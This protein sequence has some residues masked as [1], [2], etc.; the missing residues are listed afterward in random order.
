VYSTLPCPLRG[1]ASI[2]RNAGVFTPIA[3][4]V[5]TRATL[6]YSYY[7][8]V[9]SW[10]LQAITLDGIE[11]DGWGATMCLRVQDLKGATRLQLQFP[12]LKECRQ[13]YNHLQILLANRSLVDNQRPAGIPQLERVDLI[14]GRPFV[15]YQLLGAVEAKSLNR[16]HAMAALRI[17]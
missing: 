8:K 1:I 10:P 5:L 16:E 7:E 17:R 15:R 6:W 9:V 12:T 3:S 11:Q 14:P 13:W 4:L 2:I